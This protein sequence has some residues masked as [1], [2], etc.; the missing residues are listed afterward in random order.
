MKLT[1]GEMMLLVKALGHYMIDCPE[2]D[3]KPCDKLLKRL[4]DE[5]WEINKGG[6]G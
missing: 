1:H 6:K 3:Y 2:L 5:R 4:W